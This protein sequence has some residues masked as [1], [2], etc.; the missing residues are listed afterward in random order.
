[1]TAGQPASFTKSY[2]PPGLEPQVSNHIPP[3]VS[4][5]TP[6][7]DGLRP[8]GYVVK[9]WPRLSETFI[10]NEIIA[11]ERQGVLLRVFSLKNP[12]ADEPVNASARLA[13]VR[14]PVTC[15]SLRSHWKPALG[16]NLRALRRHPA[17]YARALLQA[18]SSAQWAV[19]CSFLMAAYLADIMSLEPVAHLHAHFTNSPALVTMFAHQLTGVPYSFTAHA[20]DVHVTTPPKLLRAEVERAQ[21]VITCTQFDRR[22]L[23]DL[24]S[25]ATYGKLHC[26]QRGIDPSQFSALQPHSRNGEPPV[27]LSV[28]S[29]V[30]KKG[31]Q[32][33]LAAADL[34][35]QRGCSFQLEVIGDGPLRRVLEARVAEL[36][37]ED[38]VRLRGVE[39]YEEVCRAYQ[40][41]SVFALPCVVATD[42]DRDGIPN[43]LLE[44]MASGVPVVA[45]QVSGI[46]ELIESERDGLLVEPNRPGMLADALERLLT[47]PELCERLA[48]AARAR[49]ETSFSIDQSSRRM[50]ALF[51]QEPPPKRFAFGLETA[52]RAE[53]YQPQPQGR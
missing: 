32:D 18:V 10:L 4:N 52:S 3:Q 41:A 21:A 6:Q 11:L 9:A 16:A 39:S 31:L 35:R 24:I 29:L 19:V 53:C 28:A 30:E 46:P 42:G 38:R 2:Q 33:L 25:P 49:I 20:S 36:G 5:H 15:V 17:R 43:V 7:A 13:E 51:R 22:H 27:I 26:I 23:L 34:L 8:V 47:Q 37:L 45:T 40:R 12:V 44:A 48:R 1:V 50:L 14:A